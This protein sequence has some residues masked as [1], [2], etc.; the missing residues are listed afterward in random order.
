[1]EIKEHTTP[2][3]LEYYAFM[4]SL[5]RLVIAALSLFFGATPIAYHLLGFSGTATLLPLFWLISGAAAVY[6][7]YRWHVGGQKL[8]GRTDQKERIAFL[9][10]AI[11]GINLGLVSITGTNFGMGL[12]YNMPIAQ[13]F[14]V[15]TAALYL[16]V[17]WQLWTAWNANGKQLFSTSTPAPK[18]ESGEVTASTTEASETRMEE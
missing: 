17:A 8:F 18:T 5:A 1:M 2:D 16:Y 3:R 4:W 12:I 6:L 9:V 15:I 11:T 10:M 14:F 13:I 7:G